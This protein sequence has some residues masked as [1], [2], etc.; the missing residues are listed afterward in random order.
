MAGAAG[1]ASTGEWLQYLDKE[2][3]G[4]PWLSV[5]FVL[6]CTYSLP[7]QCVSQFSCLHCPNLQTRATQILAPV[8]AAAEDLTRRRRAPP[9]SDQIKGVRRPN[10]VSYRL[11]RGECHG[12]LVRGE[13][14]EYDSTVAEPLCAHNGQK[15]LTDIL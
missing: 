7:R 5:N 8:C 6:V 1:G 11:A 15:G 3:G 2:G 14:H 4:L 9:G 12:R 13:C 10:G